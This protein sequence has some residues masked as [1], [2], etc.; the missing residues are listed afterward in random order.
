VTLTALP[1]PGFEFGGWSGGLASTANPATLLVDMDRHV[2][3]RFVPLA[4][5]LEELQTGA[6]ADLDTVATDTPLVAAEGD[7]YVAAIASKPHVTV[8]GV[9]G[10]GLAWQPLAAQCSAR[11]QTGVSLWQASG[12]PLGDEPVTATLV[13]APR[14]ALIA[15]SRYSGAVGTGA[16]ATANTLGVAGAC[17]GGSDSNAYGID[18][19]TSTAGSEVVVV[20]AMRTRDHVP[21]SAWTEQVEIYAGSG[22]GTA[23]LSQAVGVVEQPGVVHV[24]G[25]FGTPVDW[26]VLAV[27]VRGAPASQ[28]L[29]I[30]SSP[31][32]S[33]ALDPP[34][35]VYES[36]TLVTLTA[37]PDVGQ[38]FTGWS[39]DLAGAGN[40]A[41]LVMDAHKS[42]TADFGVPHSVTVET[43]PGGA[44]G[45]D[46]AGSVHGAGTL[47]ALSATPD[48][49][50]LF[51][52][53]GGDLTGAQNPTPLL[54][55]AD[56]SV[57]AIFAK[58]V[59]NV[60]ARSHGS[61]TLDPPG[62][63]YDVGTVVTLHASPKPGYVFSG[64]SGALS[65]SGNPAT[66]GMD[67]DKMVF[68]R[69]D[70]EVSVS[71]SVSTGGQVDIDPPGGVYA[72]GTHVTL[73]ATPEA[74]TLFR[75]W[76]GALSGTDNPATL[77][78]DAD[79]DV[80]A[81]FAKPVLRVVT[82][83]RGSVTLD[84]P[85]GVYE[86]GSVVT[87]HAS[88]K[89]GYVFTGWGG[90][91]AGNVNPA[92]ILMDGDGFVTAEFGTP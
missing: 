76:G 82:R 7:L 48:P 8:S 88:P 79:K 55:D 40:P 92:A 21:G 22:G 26:S 36:G 56:K 70:R 69:F 12:Q 33:V 83:S 80:T 66:L 46:P 87:L 65:G 44:V 35:G 73:T 9:S 6:S 52:A 90:D 17:S 60:I 68:G 41:T 1:A 31:G 85:G 57:A 47:V 4:L 58:P 30:G 42:V 24:D 10:L 37:T 28:A 61:V 84:P 49:G 51:R 59:L 34:G 71:V 75:T 14:G 62:G 27:E 5:T 53:W 77:V 91:L 89:P 20:A 25:S 39:G 19:E 3:A 43:T 72:P 18:L 2:V 11:G 15:V 29:S 63:V 50:Y 67:A 13:S 54:V 81:I 45:L 74:G 32:G 64:W 78:L 16:L 86:L 38:R 23:G